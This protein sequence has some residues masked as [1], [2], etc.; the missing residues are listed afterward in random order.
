MTI[1]QLN[2]I[3]PLFILFLFHCLDCDFYWKKDEKYTTEKWYLLKKINPILISDLHIHLSNALY[4]DIFSSVTVNDEENYSKDSNVIENDFSSLDPETN[5]I[6]FS[7]KRYE[8]EEFIR[9]YISSWLKW[10]IKAPYKKKIEFQ[11]K[12]FDE[13]ILRFYNEIW[14]TIQY[15]LSHYKETD[16]NEELLIIY[17]SI[18]WGISQIKGGFY[19]TDRYNYTFDFI[20]SEKYIKNIWNR[21]TISWDKIISLSPQSDSILSNDKKIVNFT[22]AESNL[23]GFLLNTPDNYSSIENIKSTTKQITIDSIKKT[24]RTIN[25]KI[26]AKGLKDFL[27]IEMKYRSGC[28]RLLWNVL[29]K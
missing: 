17:M 28:F 24:R 13:R 2:Q 1:P 4:L 27:Y 7:Y 6:S 15:K 12:E 16:L 23:L 29:K 3:H 22:E 10:E 25:L 26:K 20:L 21:S 19:I 5:K 14:D 8:V 11:L 9:E 18:N